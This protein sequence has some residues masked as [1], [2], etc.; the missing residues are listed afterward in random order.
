MRYTIAVGVLLVASLYTKSAVLAT[1][2]SGLL[3]QKISVLKH[4][5]KVCWTV[6][7]H[8]N[9]YTL[10]IL[11]IL[12]KHKIRATFFVV[13][14]PLYYYSRYPKDP[15]FKRL[16]GAFLAILK[17]KHAV[18]NHSLTHKNL[19][20]LS[21]KKVYRELKRTQK[22]VYRYSK[23]NPT[24]WRAPFLSR[25]KKTWRAARRLKLTHVPAH[26]QDYRWSAK[27]MWR[28]LRRR[29]LRGKKYSIVLLHSNPRKLRQFLQLIQQH[30]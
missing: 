5:H 20:K 9:N 26:V 30:P 21:A 29:V 7:D 8:P 27:K 16:Y 4:P 23:A 11:K 3:C 10:A 14:W 12:R 15:G 28:A 22:L 18:G 1:P 17:D 19:C 2:P 13:G 25:C 6:D 24:L